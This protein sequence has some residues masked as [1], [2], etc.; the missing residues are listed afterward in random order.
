[1]KYYVGA[2][3]DLASDTNPFDAISEAIVAIDERSAIFRPD[4][5]YHNAH[6]SNLASMSYIKECN[7][8]ALMKAD[9]AIFSLNSKVFSMGAPLEIQMRASENLKTLIITDRAGLYLKMLEVNSKVKVYLSDP[10]QE[11]KD[12]ITSPEITSWIKK[13]F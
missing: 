2:A 9:I 12:I 8:Y 13:V 1:M 3:I 4:R 6:K 5:A 11:L 7:D 10:N